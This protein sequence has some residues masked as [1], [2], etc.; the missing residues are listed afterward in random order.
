MRGEYVFVMTK[1]Q[2]F[3]RFSISISGV[4]A[5]YFKEMIMVISFEYILAQTRM[6]FCRITLP[7]KGYMWGWGQ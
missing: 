1:S 4:S 3:C 2:S 5:S 7:N 6:G